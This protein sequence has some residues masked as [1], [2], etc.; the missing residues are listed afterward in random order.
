MNERIACFLWYEFPRK[1]SEEIKP[2]QEMAALISRRID[3]SSPTLNVVY[4]SQLKG[5]AAYLHGDP[6]AFQEILEQLFAEF[7]NPC[8][9]QTFNKDAM[10][11][12]ER[13][14]I[15]HS[16]ASRQINGHDYLR[17]VKPAVLG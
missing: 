17:E 8:Q 2:L 15:K 13:V 9:Y 6:N 12:V 4:A 5:F 11:L 1:N 16:L 7:G 10:D 3:A 14:L